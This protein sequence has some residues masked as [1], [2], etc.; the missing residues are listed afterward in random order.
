MFLKDSWCYLMLREGRDKAFKDF[1]SWTCT[2]FIPRGTQA[3]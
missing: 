3:V 1:I 2:Q